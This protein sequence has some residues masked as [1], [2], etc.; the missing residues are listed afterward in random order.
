LRSGIANGHPVTVR[1][2]AYIIAG[3]AQHHYEALK[4]RSGKDADQSD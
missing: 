4:N 2:L 3:H 1:A